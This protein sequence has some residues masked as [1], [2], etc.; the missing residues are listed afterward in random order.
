VLQ[1][2]L[3]RMAPQQPRPATGDFLFAVDHCFAIKGQGTVL[4]GTCLKV[5]HRAEQSRAGGMRCE[6]LTCCVMYFM[7]CG[8]VHGTLPFDEQ[9]NA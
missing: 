5:R 1:S 7:V 8:E 6:R 9:P 4:T 3:L 2:L